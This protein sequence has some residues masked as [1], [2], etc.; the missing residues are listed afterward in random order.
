[1]SEEKKTDPALVLRVKQSQLELLAA[2]GYDIGKEKNILK[3]DPENQDH[4]EAFQ[5]YYKADRDGNFLEGFLSHRYT[6]VIKTGAVKGKARGTEVMITLVYYIPQVKKPELTRVKQDALYTI[7]KGADPSS[8]QKQ[9]LDSVIVIS[10]AAI[11]STAIK[12]LNKDLNKDGKLSFEL[13]N[14]TYSELLIN[15]T[16]YYSLPLDDI[17]NPDGNTFQSVITYEKLPDEEA[18]NLLKR[19]NILLQQLPIIKY[20]SIFNIIEKNGKMDPIVKYYNYK[21]GDIIRV[22]RVLFYMNSFNRTSIFYRHV[23]A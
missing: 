20:A 15:P 3:Y 10:E 19:N 23:F 17:E 4:L 11:D 7:T 5:D 8:D 18:I 13:Q 1:M 12:D 16:K 14:F 6:K 21:P 2:R 9:S 22:T